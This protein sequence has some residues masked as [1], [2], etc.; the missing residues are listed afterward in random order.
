LEFEQQRFNCGQNVSRQFAHLG[1]VHNE[2]LEALM[3]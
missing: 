2:K 1:V 3:F